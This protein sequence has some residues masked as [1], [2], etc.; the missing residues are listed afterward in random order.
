M[1]SRYFMWDN[2]STH[3]APLI[4]QTVEGT[5]MHNIIWRPPYRPRDAPIEYRFCNLI[6]GLQNRIFNIKNTVDLIQGIQKVVANLRGFNDIFASG[7]ALV[8]Y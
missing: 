1:D 4:H 6:T 3:C 8:G 5:Y 2:L 7:F